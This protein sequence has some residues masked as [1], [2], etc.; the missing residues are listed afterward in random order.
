MNWIPKPMDLTDIDLGENGT[1]LL[2][3]VAENTHAIW[4]KGRYS[5]GWRYGPARDD[6][7]KQTPC[8]VPY[9]ELPES[10]KEFDRQTAL[11]AIKAAIKLGMVQLVDN[12]ED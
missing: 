2:E 6:K 9:N 4:G 11:N 5:E 1:E 7:K 3:K 8:M 10:E 12:E